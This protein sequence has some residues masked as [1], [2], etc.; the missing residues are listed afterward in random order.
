[1]EVMARYEPV[2]GNVSLNSPLAL[3]WRPTLAWA[4]AMGCIFGITI[5]G[6]SANPT[7]FLY[8]RF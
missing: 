3:Q 7:S 6:I 2:L 4:V 8:F 1:M 5:A